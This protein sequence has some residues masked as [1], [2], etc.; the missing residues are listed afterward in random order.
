MLQSKVPKDYVIATG[1]NHSVKQF[2]NES[3]KVLKLNTK[4]VGKGLNE[5]LIDIKSNKTIIKIDKEYFRPSEVDD[6]K[7]NYLKAKKELKWSP[8]TK[9]S[10]LVEMMVLSDLEYVRNTK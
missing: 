6:L 7:G 1:K 9:F 8:K 2:I 3:V 4:W 10:K 5:K